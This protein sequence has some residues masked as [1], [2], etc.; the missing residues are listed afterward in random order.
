MSPPQRDGGLG[1]MLA[2][3]VSTQW[4]TRANRTRAA[5]WFSG[6]LEE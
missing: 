1:V 2:V 4:F 5:Y 6:I 3:S